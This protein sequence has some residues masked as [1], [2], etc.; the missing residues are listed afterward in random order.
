M[1]L[2]F[3]AVSVAPCVCVHALIVDPVVAALETGELIP[4]LEP[5]LAA[6]PSAV[7]KVGQ[8]LVCAGG[9]SV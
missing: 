3:V 4:T 5:V 1:C 8:C 9:G 6:A 7:G 2:C